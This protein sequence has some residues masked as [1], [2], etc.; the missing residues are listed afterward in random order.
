MRLFGRPEIVASAGLDEPRNDFD[1]EQPARHK[2]LLKQRADKRT[3]SEELSA[4]L[5][6]I[7]RQAY[8]QGG[9]RSKHPTQIMSKRAAVDGS[10]KE[11]NPCP[12]DHRDLRTGFKKFTKGGNSLEGRGHIGIPIARKVRVRVKG[13]Q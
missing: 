1:I 2:G 6:V 11:A 7:D 3:H 8:C 4:T 12:E 9:S 13:R 5:R 10:A